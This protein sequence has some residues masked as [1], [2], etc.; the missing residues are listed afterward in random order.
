MVFDLRCAGQLLEQLIDEPWDGDFASQDTGEIFGRQGAG[1]EAPGQ[2]LSRLFKHRLFYVIDHRLP[3]S[4][5]PSLF[6]VGGAFLKEVNKLLDPS[7]MQGTHQTT[8]GSAPAL[9]IRVQP[10]HGQQL[11]IQLCRPLAV[12]LVHDEN[13]SCFHQSALEELDGIAMPRRDGHNYQVG[14]IHNF[15]FILSDA[16]GFNQNRS[17]ASEAEY[18]DKGLDAQQ[19]T[20]DVSP[21]GG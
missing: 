21:G 14:H 5:A 3:S 19:Q 11:S 7:A 18:A 12:A 4:R 15:R 20:A 6:R 10:E 1:H 9:S 8:V 2:T 17:A 16:D 13:V